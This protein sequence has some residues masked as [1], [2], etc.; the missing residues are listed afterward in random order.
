[1]L[2]SIAEVLR[3]RHS[4]TSSLLVPRL[5]RLPLSTAYMR[6]YVLPTW[7]HLLDR[8][9][10]ISFRI[11]SYAWISNSL[12]HCFA[13]RRI[14]WIV[15]HDDI[16]FSSSLRLYRRKRL[17]KRGMALLLLWNLARSFTDICEGLMPLGVNV[18]F[19]FDYICFSGVQ[20]CVYYVHARAEP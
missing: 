8:V 14:L 13:P 10:Q 4:N 5:C 16:A 3:I 6:S 9:T 2:Y 1:M 18:S 15:P 12:L 19:Q 7:E 11:V 20:L 17:W